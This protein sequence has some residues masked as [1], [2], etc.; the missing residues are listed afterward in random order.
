MIVVL[1]QGSTEE[2]I[3]EV[4]RDLERRS[5][6]GRIVHAGGKPLIHVTSGST[7]RARRLLRLDQVEALVPTSGPRVR[8]EG[9]RFYPYYFVN[10]CAGF[11]LVLGLL[12]LLAGQLPSGMGV[13][14]DAQHPPSETQFPW[15]ARAPLAFVALFPESLAW[16]GWLVLLVLAGVVFFLPTLDR[17]QRRTLRERWWIVAAG[18][19]AGIGWLYLT[20]SEGAR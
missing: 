7:R 14:I 11:V 16:L 18:I 8:V 20:L 10:L 6:R 4:L 9:R 19:L 3:A 17:S 2:E 1:R 5:L 13:E 15:Y 12:V